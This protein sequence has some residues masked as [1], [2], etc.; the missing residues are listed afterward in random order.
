MAD[1]LMFDG[2]L[3]QWWQWLQ[4]LGESL[5]QVRVLRSA[6]SPLLGHQRSGS[7][8]VGSLANHVHAIPTLVVCVHGHVRVSSA[9]EQID[10]HAGEA[11]IVAPGAWHQHHQPRGDSVMYMQG[12]IAQQSD[13]CFTSAERT[14]GGMVPPEP[15]RKWLYAA[16][17]DDP[18]AAV[19]HIIQQVTQER[20]VPQAPPPPPVQ[21]M[22]HALWQHFC[23]PIHV[24]D[25]VRASGISQAQ[26]YRLWQ[27]TFGESPKVTLTN[28]RILLADELLREGQAVSAVAE[29]CGFA[30]RVAFTRA[31]KQ[32]HGVPPSY[33]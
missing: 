3:I 32:I 33:R 7:P 11:V 16:L 30:S 19:R 26:A 18:L 14:V 10:L 29:S 25:L 8:V 9:H 21:A 17:T 27:Q 13:I 5:K 28:Q 12:L 6:E 22:L 2:Q 31:Y 1:Q 4:D 24:S 15:F 23:E 20:V